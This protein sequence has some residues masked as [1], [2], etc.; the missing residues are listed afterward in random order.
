MT[1]RHT[2]R[3]HRPPLIIAALLLIGVSATGCAG[4][5]DSP[6]AYA[7]APG[8]GAVADRQFADALSDAVDAA[9]RGRLGSAAVLA[10][11]AELRAVD[12]D[13]RDAALQAAVLPG[14]WHL[15]ATGEV[16]VSVGTVESALA[17]HPIDGPAPPRTADLILATFFA[18]AGQVQRGR[19]FL[20]RYVQDARPPVPGQELRLPPGYHSARGAI[21]L[22]ERRFAEAIRALERAAAAESADPMAPGFRLGLAWDRAGARDSALRAYERFIQAV[23]PG[24]ASSRPTRADA[25][26]LPYALTGLGEAHEARGDDSN[27]AA[28]LERFIEL[29]KGADPALQDEVLETRERLGALGDPTSTGG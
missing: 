24:L 25:W 17:R 22:A 10:R 18:D 9:A 6:E 21:G 16:E 29:W 13:D 7:G 2:G 27:A 3:Q 20:S 23:A 14:L 4:G 28:Y 5:E 8:G 11:E 26:A 12:L 1:L 19:A 15:W